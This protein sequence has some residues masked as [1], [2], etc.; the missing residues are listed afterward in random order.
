MTL[1]AVARIQSKEAREN[2]G[3][4]AKGGFTARAAAAAAA[5]NSK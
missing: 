3:K 4:V 1:A 5:A 2:N